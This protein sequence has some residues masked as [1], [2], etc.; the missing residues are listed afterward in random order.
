MKNGNVEGR[1]AA[2][3]I[4]DKYDRRSAVL[5][6]KVKGRKVTEG[7]LLKIDAKSLSQVSRQKQLINT[8]VKIH[9]DPALVMEE[10][11]E[12]HKNHKKPVKSASSDKK[13]LSSKL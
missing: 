2:S 5:I 13:R 4:Y 3:K 11:F 9:Q 8:L 1:K 12:S 6:K 7:N 10:N